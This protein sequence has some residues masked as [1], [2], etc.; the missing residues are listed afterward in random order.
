[1]AFP[2][3][4]G[5]DAA[6]RWENLATDEAAKLSVFSVNGP[7]G[8][9]KTTLL[10]EIIV[11]NIIEKARLLAEYADPDEA[12]DDYSFQHGNGRDIP[13]LSG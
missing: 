5:F 6:D 13:I 4:A 3:Y 7:P 11:S 2:F 12:F 1:M 10:K 8:T 9:G